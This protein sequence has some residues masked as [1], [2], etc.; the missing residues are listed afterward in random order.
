M[1]RF[2]FVIILFFS[3][4]VLG[5]DDFI[6]IEIHANNQLFSDERN[7]Y[8][9]SLDT[10]KGSIA[11]K[12]KLRGS[13]PAN[14]IVLYSAEGSFDYEK[15]ADG[16]VYVETEVGAGTGFVLE[17]GSV[18]TNWH[19]VNGSSFPPKVVFRPQSNVAVELEYT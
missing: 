13:A 4:K 1:V 2:I 6:K 7:S 17:D 10:Y 12:I 19:V 11:N 9:D 15:H 14:E 16:I 3:F 5:I 8:F 18:V